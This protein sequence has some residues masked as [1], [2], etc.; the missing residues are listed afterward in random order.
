MPDFDI[1]RSTKDGLFFRNIFIDLMLMA[2]GTFLGFSWN[3][4]FK[5]IIQTYMPV[6]SNLMQKVGLQIFITILM[7]YFG[8]RLLKKKK[9]TVF[10]APEMQ[11]I[12]SS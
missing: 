12:P 2:I 5:E 3:D 7:A 9:K 6:G 10:K 4:L 11:K 1:E 8:W